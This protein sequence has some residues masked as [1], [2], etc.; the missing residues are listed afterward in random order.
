MTLPATRV[1]FEL[2]RKRGYLRNG[3]FPNSIPVEPSNIL[4]LTEMFSMESI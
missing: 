4:N 3:K 2:L 1:R